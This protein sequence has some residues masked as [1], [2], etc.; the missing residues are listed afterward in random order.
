MW[1]N[2]NVGVLTGHKSNLTIIDKGGEEGQKSID[3]L[4]SRFGPL[5][6][7]LESRS[8]QGGHLYFQYPAGGSIGNSAGKLGK[9]LDVRAEGGYIIAPLSVHKRGMN[10]NWVLNSEPAPLPDWIT[11]IL[12]Q[13][14]RKASGDNRAVGR[15]LQGQRN[16]HLTS[17]AGST[18]RLDMSMSA[19]EAALLEENTLRCDPPLRESEVR[20]IAQSVGRY[21]A[22]Q[23][24][25]DPLP[26]P[27]VLAS[28]VTPKIVT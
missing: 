17:L 28:E 13:P 1:P 9:G 14:G 15:I 5:P 25:G 12:A 20:S 27:G 6:A 4:E 21:G 26:V 2:S 11:K 22:T 19:I 3:D 8:G 10:Y 23:K 7:T 24:P 16:A 18:R